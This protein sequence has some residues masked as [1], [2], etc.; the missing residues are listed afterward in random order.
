[1][2]GHG[3]KLVAAAQAQLRL[4][5]NL[6]TQHWYNDWQ[7]AVFIITFEHLMRALRNGNAA[8]AERLVDKLTVYLFV[9]FLC[10]E[11]GMSW[12]VANNALR[13]E[14]LRAHQ[15]AHIRELDIWHETV[16]APFKASARRDPRLI[17]RI[18]DFY[19]RILSHIDDVDQQCYG[20]KTVRDDAVQLDEVA[21]V[22]RCGLPLSPNMAGAVAI[23]GACD[24]Q[25]HSLL[26]RD[27][28]PL[29]STA[30]LKPLSLI[31]L[32]GDMEND[33]LRARFLRATRA[34]TAVSERRAA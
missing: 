20:N 25:V 7:H 29:R 32:H 23:V 6:R 3:I 19:E 26:K 15:A 22:A 13:P 8:V 34:G 4:P 31:S 18:Q 5:P 28:L 27:G 14:A 21:H 11:E 16:Q 12:A 10:E 33:T 9:H 1:M 2:D 30:P 17:S 24:G